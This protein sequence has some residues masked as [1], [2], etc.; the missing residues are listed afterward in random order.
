MSLGVG[1]GSALRRPGPRI[2]V[3]LLAA[4]AVLAVL[5]ELVAPQYA[6]LEAA[7]AIAAILGLAVLA[8]AAVRGS[9]SRPPE[10]AQH[11]DPDLRELTRAK[12]AAEAASAAKSLYLATVSHE[13]RSPLNAIYGYAQLMERETAVSP[14]DAARIIRRSTEYLTDLVEGLLDISMVEQGVMRVARDVVR[15]PAFLD[16]ITRMLEPQAAAKGLAFRIETRGRLPE[17]VRADQKRLRQILINLVGNAIKYTDR[18]EVTLTVHHASEIA[19]FEVRDTGPGIPEASHEHIFTPFERGAEAARGSEGSGLGLAITRAIVHVLGGDIAL[20]STPG[21]GSMFRV[22][23]MLA[24]VFGHR[25]AAPA[26]RITG[27]AGPRRRVLVMDDDV[28][29]LAFISE[30]LGGLGF[31]VVTAVDGRSALALFAAQPFDLVLLDIAVPGRTGWEIAADLRALGQLG[32]GPEPRIVML[33]GNAHERHG[34]AGGGPSGGPESGGAESGGAG[35]PAHDLF[36]VKPIEIGALVDA[37]GDQLG[38]RWDYEAPG[39]ADAA[40]PRGD[41]IALPEAARGPVERLRE[42]LKIGHVRGV[43]AE[44]RAL[45]VVAPE[46]QALV[47]A[48]YASL[49]RF[50]LAAMTRQLEGL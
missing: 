17:F 9:L 41:G 1:T 34:P 20:E 33:S 2:A 50:D 10:S 12:D 25:E 48:L 3:G 37:L 29:Q 15:L 31:D 13:L 7:L 44:I 36:L 30:V 43:E 35:P 38:L 26:R 6:D 14:R 28:Q 16:Q 4:G 32:K 8:G 40:T 21:A 39:D 23:L 24:E 22:R 5:C 11:H 27:Y 19:T 45:E 46:A 42:L 18:G 47:K 49:D